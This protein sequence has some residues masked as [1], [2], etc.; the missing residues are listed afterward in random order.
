MTFIHAAP[1]GARRQRARRSAAH[2]APPARCTGSP[3]RL[4]KR[5][6]VGAAASNQRPPCAVGACGS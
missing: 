6:R 5:R 4:A 1:L 2:A 3:A